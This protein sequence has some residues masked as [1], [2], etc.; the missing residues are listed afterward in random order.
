MEKKKIE[1]FRLS[2]VEIKLILREKNNEHDN[3]NI[4]RKMDVAIVVS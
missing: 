2:V 4:F 3:I 1:I